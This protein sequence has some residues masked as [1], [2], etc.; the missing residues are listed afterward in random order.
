M[1]FIPLMSPDIAQEDIEAVARVLRSGMLVQGEEVAGFEAEVAAY[2]GVRNAIAVS[3]GTASLHLAL[4]ALGVGP[5]DEVIVPAFSHVATANV[6]ELVGARCV[7]VDVQRDTFNIDPNAFEQA[8]TSLTKAVIPVHE[9]GLACEIGRVVDLARAHGVAVIED[10]AC[11][12]GAREDGRLV[13]SFGEIGSFSLHPRKAVTSGEGGIITTE[14][15]DL[16]AR[17]RILR[18]HG[19]EMRDGKTEFVAAGFNY[20]MTD[21]QAAMVRGQFRKLDD[22][23]R[24]R[25][26]L[27]SV[28]LERLHGESW[29]TLPVV[30]AD[31]NHTWQ[32]FHPVLDN[33][34]D[35]DALVA[36]LLRGGVG[37][38]YGA[39]CI[40]EQ[41][42]YRQAY[43]LDSATLFPNA[44]RAY[45]HGL[46]L[47]LYG[48]MT[49]EQAV[50]VTETLA[51]AV[52]SLR[53]HA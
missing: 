17:F 24:T 34:I 3:N 16:A 10:A 39:Q 40:P 19:I 36:E 53:A 51:E 8:I 30:P 32:T 12:L 22:Q 37:S 23:F 14:D 20:R 29:L 27:A 42:Y 33:L 28:Y 41:A 21:F 18:N 15:D 38:N 6:V 7:F 52:A 47:P 46:A 25:G 4:V 50:Q 26:E 9:F 2:L 44:M 5:G 13:G 48:K 11:A 49:R 45:R 1:N 35:R 43:D 31:K